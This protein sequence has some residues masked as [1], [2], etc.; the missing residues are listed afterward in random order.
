M[1][2]LT[3]VALEGSAVWEIN[4]ICTSPSALIL[5]VFSTYLHN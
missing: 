4:P 3:P 2:L 1:L 5:G